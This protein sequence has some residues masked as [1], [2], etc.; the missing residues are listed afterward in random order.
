M[1]E[2][3]GDLLRHKIWGT[4][5]TIEETAELLNLSRG[6]LYNY[7]DM[8]CL[9]QAFK[10]ILQYKLGIEIEQNVQNIDI[11]D[12]PAAINPSALLI[13]ARKKKKLSPAQVAEKLQITLPNYQKME[14]GYFSLD[15]S[16]IKQIDKLL[17]TNLYKTLHLENATMASHF[18]SSSLENY[19]E[20]PYLSVYDQ[21][22]Y[23]KQYAIHK[24]QLDKEMDTLL[25]PKEFET[26]FYMVIELGSECMEDGTQKAICSGDKILMK[27]ITL[28]QW[29]EKRLNYEGHIFVLFTNSNGIICSQI[30]KH[31]AA[32]QTFTCHFWNKLYTDS[33]IAIKDIYRLFY[34][35]KIIERKIRL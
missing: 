33:S 15:K 12:L 20:V 29:K 23:A 31:I 2:K 26:G 4:G 27:E 21:I 13:E 34:V 25:V 9:P 32:Q 3:E 22:N 18:R 16:Q 7:F 19:M 6:T 24:N 35:K 11:K 10:I 28:E 1:K 5:R 14:K 30:V 8:E 17:G